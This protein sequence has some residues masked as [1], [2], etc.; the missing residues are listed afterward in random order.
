MSSRIDPEGASRTLAVRLPPSL[1]RAVELERERLSKG[2][3]HATS[4]DALRSLL[5]VAIEARSH[6]RPESERARTAERVAGALTL[7]AN[8][9]RE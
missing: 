2:H 4:A 8:L 7:L 3:T 1:L 9:L 5:T 6:A